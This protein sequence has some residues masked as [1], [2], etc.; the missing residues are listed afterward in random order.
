MEKYVR[1]SHSRNALT[2]GYYQG[3][4][5]VCSYGQFK[6]LPGRGINHSFRKKTQTSSCS[7][8][9]LHFYTPAFNSRYNYYLQSQS[10]SDTLIFTLILNRINSTI[11]DKEIQVIALSY[12]VYSTTP[13]CKT[14]PTIRHYWKEFRNHCGILHFC[15]PRI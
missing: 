2:M 1:S 5:A 8:L 11:F 14:N 3:V 9:I 7:S 10:I 12:H 6:E 4:S 15:I 13:V